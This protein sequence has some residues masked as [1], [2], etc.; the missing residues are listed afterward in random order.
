MSLRLDHV[1]LLVKDLATAITDFEQIGFKVMVGGEHT[2]G[3]THNALIIFEEDN[4]IELIAFKRAEPNHRWWHYAET[5]G[6]GFIDFAFVPDNLQVEVDAIR[7]R[8]LAVTGP[9]DGGR[10]RPDGQEVRWQNASFA[11][12]ELPFLCADVTPREVRVPRAEFSQHPNGAKG[13]LELQIS[14]AGNLTE[15][16]EQFEKLVGVKPE[17]TQG[18][19][20]FFRLDEC[21]IAYASRDDSKQVQLS[22]RG[23]KS[24]MLFNLHNVSIMLEPEKD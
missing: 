8:G 6:E 1:V 18:G 13:I 9:S 14:L 11:S 19:V 10:L 24:Q 21:R 5:Q 15:T 4:Y 22:I 2:G 12:P 17:I 7:A 23:G 16:L 20:A 3:A